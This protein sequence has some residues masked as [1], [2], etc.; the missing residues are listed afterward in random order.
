MPNCVECGTDVYDIDYEGE[1]IRCYDC[2]Y[3][4]NLKKATHKTIKYCLIVIGGFMI[5]NI[6]FQLTLGFLFH[7]VF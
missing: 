4:T 3:H 6:M 7:Y 5:F 2:I 1:E